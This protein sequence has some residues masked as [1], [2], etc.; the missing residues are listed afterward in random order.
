MA[1]PLRNESVQHLDQE[2]EAASR[3]PQLTL[4]RTGNAIAA[5]RALAL[6]GGLC[7]AFI[8]IVAFEANIASGQMELDKLNKTVSMARDH[9]EELRQ[10]RAML[11]A[12]DVLRTSAEKSMMLLAPA[13]KFLNVEKSVVAVVDEAISGMDARFADPP[14]STL[15]EFGH[16]KITLKGRG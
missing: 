9:Y 10:E 2:V 15:D 11:H 13:I 5:R 14:S 8:G 1:M 6:V 16:I 3:R 12:P 4:I 7:L